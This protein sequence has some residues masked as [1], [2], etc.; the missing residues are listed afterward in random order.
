MADNLT[1][2]QRKRNMANIRSRHTKPELIVRSLIHRRGF[3]FRLH[4]K[5]LPGK[6]DIV[7][8]RHKKNVLVHGCF[9]H[10]HWCKRGSVTPKTNETY[11]ARKRIRNSVRDK[12]NSK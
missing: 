1:F 4:Y 8:P 11:W 5:E 3:R 10:M 6:P 9:W 2:D 7:L 12:E